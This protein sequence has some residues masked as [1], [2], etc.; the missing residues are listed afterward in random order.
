MAKIELLPT[1]L[2]D[3]IA[4]GEVIGSPTSI[5]KEL[6]ENAIDA[7]SQNITIH[8]FDLHKIIIEDDGDGIE[9][10]DM[11]KSILRHATSKIKEYE[12]LHRLVSLGF[13]GEA[14]SSIASVTHLTIKSRSQDSDYAIQLTAR[15]GQIEG[16]E[17]MYQE[18]GTIVIVDDIFYNVPVRKKFLKNLS[19]ENKEI[20]RQIARIAL[21]Y[22]KITF[23]YYR[24]KKK[25]LQLEKV[26]SLLE[27][28]SQ[29]FGEE[30]GKQM[31]AVNFNSL[32]YKCVGLIG[33]R[34]CYRAHRDMQFE[35][36]NN[37]SVEL[38]NFS[39]SVKRAYNVLLPTGSF[40]V[41]FL[42][43]TLSPKLVDVNVH[44]QK[45]EVLL[46]FQVAFFDLVPYLSQLI[47]PRKIFSISEG[48]AKIFQNKVSLPIKKNNPILPF[49]RINQAVQSVTIQEKKT[50]HANGQLQRHF[51]V[52]YGTYI[53]AQLD[54]C[55]TIIDQHAAHERI[56]YERYLKKMKL[57]DIQTQYL[58]KPLVIYCNAEE[59]TLI[60]KNKKKLQNFGYELEVWEKSYGIRTTPIYFD[61]Q[62]SSEK[63]HSF[64]LR[65][66][67]KKDSTELFNDYIATRAC[68]VSIKKNDVVS[69]Q[70]ISE[71]IQQLLAC[72]DP[73]ICPHGRPTMIKMDNRA[74]DKLFDRS[75]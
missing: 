14:L 2:V 74:L 47:H 29:I 34:E 69:E 6:I 55:F 23:H 10:S 53:L 40:P 18:R 54:D 57:N 64:L 8:T 50:S 1:I 66:L 36:V 72:E 19:H 68:K 17:K 52:L 31:L 67:E 32:N 4:A 38:K 46:S 12:D 11:E 65:A 35:Y 20:Q 63:F 45:K 39:F 51:G 42:F 43:F 59:L 41:Y 15:G 33:S 22:P 21:A 60:R 3:K 73:S 48:Q 44:P 61:Q 13:R 26:D 58:L 27:R 9:P 70:I 7:G 56:N 71:V 16:L 24:N 25:V 30:I 49:N 28:I 5:V 75:K 37:R 62:I